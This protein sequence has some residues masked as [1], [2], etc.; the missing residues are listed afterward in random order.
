M[1]IKRAVVE[2]IGGLDPRF[3]LGNFEDDD[4]SL[5]ARLAGFESWIAEDCFVHH[6]GS[7]TFAGAKINYEESLRKNWSLF[8][9][10]WGIPEEVEYG[11]PYD[12]SQAIKGGFQPLLHYCPLIPHG[13]SLFQGEALFTA[14]NLEGAKTVFENLLQVD[15]ENTE[16]LNNLRVIAF[17][18]G[19]TEEAISY[20]SRVLEK[21]ACHLDV[22]EN[23]GNCLLSPKAYQEVVPWFRRSVELRPV[24]AR[25]LNAVANCY[26]Q[27]GDFREVQR[28]CARSIDLD[29]RQSPVREILSELERLKSCG[30]ERRISL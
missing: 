10:K 15:S 4:F 22:I 8:K 24:E 6:F 25:L 30:P 2:R 18:E 9:R 29:D 27:S 14:G 26:I 21:E 7:R 17:A 28:F 19:K 13:Y 12:L 3:G 5:R 1:L 11:T 23:L 20:F 16:V